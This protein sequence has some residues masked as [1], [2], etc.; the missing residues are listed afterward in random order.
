M[1]GLA[2]LAMAGIT[3]A[4]VT[5][6]E[7][8]NYAAGT[9]ANGT[10]VT[11]S[12]LTGN[13]TCG[14]A[15]TIGTGLTYTGLPVA[16]NAL[17]SG[18]GRQFVSLSSPLSSGTKWISFLFYA[19]GNMGGNIDGVFF[20]NGNSTCLWF[21]FGLNPYSPSQGQLGLGS[22]TTAGTAA[23]GATSLQQVGLGNY[24][25][26]Y[27]I[28]L[29]IDFNTSGANDTV[30]VYTNPVANASAPGVTAAGTCSSYDVGTISGV[31]LNVQGGAN[32]TVDEIR[33]GDTYSDVVG[34]VS[35]P[36]NAPTG[37]NAT[38]GTNLVA[39]SWTAATGSP[40]S[41]NVKRSTTSGSG[42]TTVGTTTA[43]TVAYN[44]SVLGGQ[45]YYYVV[46]A[47]NGGGESTNSSQVSASPTLAAPAA[48]TGLAATPGNA[49]VTLSWTASASATNYNVK[50]AAASAGP[51]TPIGTTTA[52]MV[53]Y[54]DST[55]LNN[56]TT[57]YYV[58]SATGPGGTSSDT[59]P[60]S[61]TPAVPIP[62]YEPFNYPAGTL[63]NG[64]A[65]TGS[66]LTGTWTCGAAGTITTGLT[67]TGLPVANNAL[68]SASGR[69]FVSL[70]SPLSSGT[71]WISFL[72][73]ASGNMGGNID[74]VF[75]PNGNST[76]LWFGFGLSPYS[77]TQGQLGLGSMTTA[78]TAA[79]GATSLQQVGL[80]NYA[81][82]SLIVLKIDFNT[83]GAN[84]T[85]TVY[86]NPVANASAPGMTA[87]GTCSS[88]DVGTISGIG[89]NVQGSANIMV[90]EIRVGDTYG[91]VV[92]FVSIPPNAPTGLTATPGA[93]LVSLSWTAATG[94]PNS[95][96]VKRSTTSGSGYTTVGTTTAP[97]VTYNDSVLGGQPYYYVVTAVNGGGESSPSSQVSASPT[98][99]APAVPAGLAA[100][101]GNAQVVLSWSASSFATSYNV[102]RAAASAGPYTP[103][104]TTTATT[105]TYTDSTGLNNGTTYYYAV[106]AT[107]PGGTSSDTSPVSATPNG[108]RAL[109]AAIAR[110]AGI[111]WF[112][113][114]SVTYQVQWSSSLLGTNTVWN[115]LGSSVAGNGATNTVF[116][117]VGP[118][119]NFYQVL[120]IQ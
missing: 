14:A 22:M 74:G 40:T 12:G 101:P 19:S 120:S 15:G 58:V 70:S 108:P 17:S 94:S 38:P 110:G 57:Y 91:D 79:Q 65:A 86:T 116:D 80:G 41:Y 21:G 7:P 88:Y 35:T 98:L 18:S 61:A 77:T 32:I 113:S 81:S 48:P 68:S 39:L 103:I 3:H 24:T 67:Y 111:R 42:Y 28:V 27:L 30:T 34:Y 43:P 10:A 99:A 76:C 119:H 23:Q 83:S 93:N 72:F 114:N 59:S 5:A 9:L 92:G 89:L 6:Y 102:K 85:V 13:W 31:G 104:G 8:F 112:A 1:A 109:L 106:S 54:I 52:P 71:K 37:L 118:P 82:T 96:N 16:N 69:Q 97:T 29:R 53:T 87:A 45:T 75:F 11:G 105:V 49:Q 95:Y 100:T 44:D 63:A 33:V 2:L 4:A 20:P 56:G 25:A 36:P 115:N 64:T 107:G 78:G 50:R 55:G 90:D 84:D 46:S 73:Y 117:P 26:T 51:Y 47:V 62:V 60:V 66:G